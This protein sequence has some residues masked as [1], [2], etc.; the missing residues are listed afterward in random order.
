MTLHCTTWVVFAIAV[1]YKLDMRISNSFSES[2]IQ[3]LE[4]VL[5]TILRGGSPGMAAR[6]KDFPSLYRKVLAMKAKVE[7]KLRS[8][9]SEIESSSDAVYS[10]SS[11]VSSGSELRQ[12]V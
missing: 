1:C 6:H 11:Q 4:F 10:A 9:E 12:A 7:E 8:P 3:I 2:E 5:Q